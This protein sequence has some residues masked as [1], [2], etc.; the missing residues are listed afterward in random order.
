MDNLKG[1]RNR[2]CGCLV[3]QMRRDGSLRRT[4]GMRRTPEF[5]VWSHLRQRCYNPKNISYPRYGGRGITVCEAWRGSF[6][7]FY[8][9][10]GPRPSPQ[11]SIERMDNDGP[12]AAWNCCWATAKEQANNRRPRRHR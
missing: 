7:A 12:Y 3:D 2:S 5:N 4:H 6:E 1:G 8:A 10:M 11:H 9:D